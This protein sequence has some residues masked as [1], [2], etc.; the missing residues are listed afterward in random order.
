MGLFDIFS[1]SPGTKAANQGYKRQQNAISSGINTLKDSANQANSALTSGSNNAL[2]YLDQGNSAAN[3]YYNRAL[4]LYNL[5][6]PTDTAAYNLR[7]NALGVNGQAAADAARNS[8]QS[9]PGYQY[10]VDEANKNILRNA[11]ATGGVLSGNTGIALSDRAGQLANQDWQQWLSNLS[12]FDPHQDITGQSN[13]LGN[14]ASLA[15]GTAAAK[16]GIAGNLG[17]GQAANLMTLGQQIAAE[18]GALGQ[19]GYQNAQDIYGAQQ[20]ASGNI[21]NALLGLGG[22]GLGAAGQA[23]GFSKLLG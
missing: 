4:Q 12:S 13:I 14:Q 17:S 9:S 10:Q 1:S 7:A 16:A 8:F 20:T 11:A 5:T 15:S 22:A 2:G 3:D 23:G 21:W 19:A 18:K 6:T